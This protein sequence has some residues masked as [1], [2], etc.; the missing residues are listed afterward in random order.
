M[1]IARSYPLRLGKQMSAIDRQA[2]SHTESKD[3]SPKIIA[4][5]RFWTAI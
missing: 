1:R 4:F 3:A 2:L 5:S